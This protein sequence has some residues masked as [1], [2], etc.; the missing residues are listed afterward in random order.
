MA[1]PNLNAPPEEEEELPDLNNKPAQEED[2]GP[3]KDVVAAGEG[4]GPEVLPCLFHHAADQDVEVHGVHGG[5]TSTG[6]HSGLNLH[7]TDESISSRPF[8][9]NDHQ[10]GGELAHPFDLNDHYHEQQQQNLHPEELLDSDGG[11]DQ[12]THGEEEDDQAHDDEEDE[13]P[14]NDEDDDQPHHDK[15]PYRKKEIT[16]RQRRDIFE[17]LLWTS[18]NGRLT[19][20]STTIIAAKYNVH[21]RRVQ[22]VWQRAKKC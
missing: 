22:R 14:H 10:N 13:Q 8:D 20:N 5:D 19:R 6:H 16:D 15:A 17:D 12:Q 9:L 2:D 1:I 18:N 7:E 4:G 11:Q 21:I 3:L